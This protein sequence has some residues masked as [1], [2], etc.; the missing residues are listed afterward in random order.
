MFLPLFR[1]P[2]GDY[3][4]NHASRPAGWIREVALRLVLVDSHSRTCTFCQEVL[5]AAYRLRFKRLGK[6]ERRQLL[7]AAQPHEKPKPIL[8]P[9]ASQALQ[10]ATRRAISNLARAGLIRVAP[11]TLRINPGEDPAILKALERKYAVLRLASRTHLG[12]QIV[13]HYQDELENGKRIRWSLHLDAS[14][15]AALHECPYRH[16]D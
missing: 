16:Q 4:K 15:E 14:T 3:R 7:Q 11:H 13:I 8:L 2:W 1:R 10:T 6:H 5:Q 12:Q 9:G